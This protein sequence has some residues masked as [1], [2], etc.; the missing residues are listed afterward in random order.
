M[1]SF[2]RFF[3]T[4]IHQHKATGEW[5]GL[6]IWPQLNGA[7]TPLKAHAHWFLAEGERERTSQLIALMSRAS[8]RTLLAKVATKSAIPWLPPDYQWCDDQV[9]GLIFLAAWSKKARSN[10]LLGIWDQVPSTLTKR[11]IDKCGI[12]KSTNCVVW[13]SIT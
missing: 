2:R 4:T 9:M 13:R 6:P 7:K 3:Q 8:K 5:L 10:D 1:P 12:K 11:F